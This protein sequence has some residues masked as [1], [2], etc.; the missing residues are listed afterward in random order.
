MKRWVRCSFD[1]ETNPRDAAESSIDMINSDI[2]S[3]RNFVKRYANKLKNSP[4][5]DAAMNDIVDKMAF[6]QHSL[7]SIIDH[8]NIKHIKEE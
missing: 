6:L 8:Y 1:P 5:D 2:T 7:D 3:I 4:D